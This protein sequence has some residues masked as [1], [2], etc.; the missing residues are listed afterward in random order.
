MHKFA[1]LQARFAWIVSDIAAEIFELDLGSDQVVKAILLPE[2]AG[3]L[4]TL[5][6]RST[7]ETFPFFTLFQHRIIVS[8]RHQHVNVIR[9]DHEICHPVPI[10]IKLQQAVRDSFCVRRIFQHTVPMAFVEFVVPSRRK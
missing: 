6:D 5:V 4:Q 9:H 2:A 3:L 1:S 10:S 8:K 7:S